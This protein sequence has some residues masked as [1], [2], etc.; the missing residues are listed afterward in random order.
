MNGELRHAMGRHLRPMLTMGMVAFGISIGA[1]ASSPDAS[2]ERTDSSEG[3][4]DSECN[5]KSDGDRCG[6]SSK[7]AP[8]VCDRGHCRAACG[9]AFNTG[10]IGSWCGFLEGC[11]G[12]N[13]AFNDGEGRVIEKLCF[14][15][16]SSPARKR[17]RC[18]NDVRVGGCAFRGNERYKCVDPT[19]QPEAGL[20]HSQ[21]QYC[22]PNSDCTCNTT[23]TT[24][25]NAVERDQ[26]A[27]DARTGD[28]FKCVNPR[29][30]SAPYVQNSQWERC[31]PT[32]TGCCTA[33]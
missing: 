8:E 7:G 15:V 23:A 14:P 25:D 17:R 29:G 2:E 30:E 13:N 19:G 24:C 27:V 12:L 28:K 5:G 6:T 18:D 31:T 32:S 1:C 16:G 10:P 4:L 3:A 33:L 9:S 20:D 11:R 26:C 22:P 21:W